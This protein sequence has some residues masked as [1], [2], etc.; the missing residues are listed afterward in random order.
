MNLEYFLNKKT[1]LHLN[2]GRKLRGMIIE[3]IDGE[4]DGMPYT[5]FYYRVNHNDYRVIYTYEI[6]S[7]DEII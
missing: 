6:E 2:D 1:I 3:I 4:D 7:I 5:K